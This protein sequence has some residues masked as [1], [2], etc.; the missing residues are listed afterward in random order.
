MYTKQKIDDILSDPNDHRST[1]TRQQLESITFKTLD[2]NIDF[3]LGLVKN[4]RA[5]GLCF[6]VGEES[7]SYFVTYLTILI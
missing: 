3:D 4:L 1:Q 7:R 2:Y 6:R 5:I